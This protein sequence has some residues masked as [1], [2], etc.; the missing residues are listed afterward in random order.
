VY[1]AGHGCFVGT[2]EYW[3]LSDT[4]HNPNEAV[5][6]NE[7]LEQSRRCGIPNVVLLSDAC[8]STSS[9]LGIQELHGYVIFPTKNNANVFTYLDRFLAAR[10]GTPAYEARDTA[11]NYNGIYTSCFLDAYVDP[12]DSMTE[13]VNGV[14]VVPNKKL[15]TYLLKVV[16]LRALI[17]NVEQYPDSI[18]TSS[19]YVGRAEYLQRQAKPGSPEVGS[20]PLTISDIAEFELSNYGFQIGTSAAKTFSAAALQEAAQ[21]TGFT[22]TS[23]SI[24]DGRGP[25]IFR[26][27][28]GINV[29]GTRLR[30]TISASMEAQILREGDG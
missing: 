5:S 18:V 25:N 10:I 27:G 26:Y 29:F 16:P 23:A 12:A 1:F 28:T 21:E 7:C 11:E 17:S 24:L 8:R 4:L 6:V 2:G 19:D 14:R 15:E 13:E 30:R 20:T 3:L 22:A 9:S